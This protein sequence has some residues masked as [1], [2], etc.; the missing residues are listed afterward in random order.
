MD[1]PLSRRTLLASVATTTAVAT[2]GFESKPL[3][4][5]RYDCSDGD[6]PEPNSPAD[7]DALEPRPY[8]DLSSQTRLEETNEV[9]NRGP[10]SV[11]LYGTDRYVID[12]ER[13]Y[14]RNAFVAQYGSTARRFEFRKTAS[15]TVPIDSAA[16]WAALL[17]A[18]LY[19]V[20]TGTRQAIGRSRNEW[21][22]RATYYVDENVVLRARY[23][24]VAEELAFDPDPRIAGRSR[25]VR[26][27]NPAVR[28][29][30]SDG[31]PGAVRRGHPS[32]PPP[33][34]SESCCP[35]GRFVASV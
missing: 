30:S 13:A 20:R 28:A 32:R 34:S 5:D 35:L 7:E 17:V 16:D 12:F 4:T 19:D 21:G 3:P 15:R 11:P 2:S 1:R 22:V 29:A 9:S 8:P 31:A 26:R 14:R 27:L 25:R 23:D 10:A 33:F 24:G 6:R 18:L